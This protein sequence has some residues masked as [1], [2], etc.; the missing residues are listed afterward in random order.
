MGHPRRSLIKCQGIT[1]PG[2]SSAVTL[3]GTL[4]NRDEAL[5]LLIDT[6]RPYL[7]KSHQ[8][9]SEFLN[10]ENVQRITG[11]SGKEYFVEICVEE[12]NEIDPTLEVIGYASEVGGRLWLSPTLTAGFCIAEDNSRSQ[13]HGWPDGSA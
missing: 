9:L 2:R 13:F 6:L 5:V 4:M 7:E 11:H 12:V 8:E 10:V 1:S 3:S